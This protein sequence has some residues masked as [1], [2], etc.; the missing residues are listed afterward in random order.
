M[1]G[2]PF[3]FPSFLDA[4]AEKLKASKA[5]EST[6]DDAAFLVGDLCVIT[7]G[8]LEALVYCYDGFWLAPR[9]R[10][11]HDVSNAA[12]TVSCLL[13]VVSLH[14]TQDALP[15]AF[16]QSSRERC[17]SLGYSGGSI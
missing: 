12:L 13:F 17:P 14:G 3:G 15:L 2:N 16:E 1:L 5:A 10:A 9:K 4:I 11:E 7:R 8:P 6:E